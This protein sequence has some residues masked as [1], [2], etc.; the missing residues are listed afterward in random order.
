MCKLR[1]KKRISIVG[2]IVSKLMMVSGLKIYLWCDCIVGFLG[3][4]YR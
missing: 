2:R 4:I 1:G 3:V